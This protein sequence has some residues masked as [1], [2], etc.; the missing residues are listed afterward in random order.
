[1]IAVKTKP[2]KI[3][4]SGNER[5]SATLTNALLSPIHFRFSLIS[6]RPR[7]SMPKPAAI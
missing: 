1:M 3:P 5:L 7:N 2:T 6:E 4:S